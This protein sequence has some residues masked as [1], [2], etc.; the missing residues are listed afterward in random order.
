[1]RKPRRRLPRL[2]AVGAAQP[3]ERLR[4]VG[5]A[6]DEAVPRRA[7]RGGPASALRAFGGRYRVPRT[8]PLGVGDG[9]GVVAAELR[10]IIATPGD[11]GDHE[12]GE[13][14]G[15]SLFTELTADPGKLGLETLLAEIAKLKRVRAIGLPADLFGDV[16]EKRI[17]RWRAR[18][19]AEHPSTLRRDHPEGV[20]LTLLAVL[21]WCRLTE[22]TDSLADLFCD[23]SGSSTPAPNGGLT[24]SNSRSSAGSATTRAC[25][26]SWPARRRTTRTR[27]CGRR[28]TRWSGSRR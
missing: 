3:S 25:C 9:D 28:C 1:M 27:R 12:D 24:R 26:S 8:G 4:S 2:R 17:A 5:Q 15:E 20:T 16:A 23:W 6:P 21:C 11:V 18:A 7:R 22:L 13:A 19:A 10:S 14:E